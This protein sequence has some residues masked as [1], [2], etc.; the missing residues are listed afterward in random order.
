MQTIRRLDRY[1]FLIKTVCPSHHLYPASLPIHIFFCINDNHVQ[2]TFPHHYSSFFVYF[3]L[4]EISM[5]CRLPPSSFTIFVFLW[6]KSYFNWF[7]R[8]F[9]HTLVCFLIRVDMNFWNLFV[10]IIIKNVESQNRVFFFTLRDEHDQKKVLRIYWKLLR[11]E[12]PK[13]RYEQ[14]IMMI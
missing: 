3:T 5:D 8:T 2:F 4:R 11:D 1:P 9:L 10:K 12:D 7:S 6:C 13:N 14:I